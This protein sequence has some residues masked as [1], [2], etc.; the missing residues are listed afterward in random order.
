MISNGASII[1]SMVIIAAIKI[2]FL[3][4]NNGQAQIYRR[5]CAPWPLMT[6]QVSQLSLP[7]GPPVRRSWINRYHHY[8][9][10]WLR[11]SH[12]Y[13]K[14]RIAARKKNPPSS[15][16]FFAYAERS[17]CTRIESCERGHFF[18]GWRQ[19][20]LRHDAGR[21]LSDRWSRAYE[22]TVSLHA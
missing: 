22:L 2:K 19:Q 16:R 10:R 13:N 15:S 12:T 7:H 17:Y 6:A 4:S 20:V 14:G 18:S 3:P 9:C 5:P 8:H 11:S 21:S 1:G